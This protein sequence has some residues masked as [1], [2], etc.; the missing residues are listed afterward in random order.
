MSA[1]GT[2][3]TFGDVRYWSAYEANVM[4]NYFEGQLTKY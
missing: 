1:F 4:Q 3:Q 2:K